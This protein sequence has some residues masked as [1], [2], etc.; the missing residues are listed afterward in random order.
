MTQAERL[1]QELDSSLIKKEGARKENAF[2]IGTERFS[3]GKFDLFFAFPWQ[4]KGK[5]ISHIKEVIF[6]FS[7][8]AG[9]SKIESCS[10]SD[11]G[12]TIIF[13]PNVQKRKITL[14]VE[15]EEKAGKILVLLRILEC[16]SR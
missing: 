7:K 1:M 3:P 2:L 9:L 14:I 8:V 6:L 16:S 5:L 11:S 4:D 13:D 12:G 10:F 15:S